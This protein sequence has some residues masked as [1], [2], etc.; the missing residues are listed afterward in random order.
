MYRWLFIAVAGLW[1]A[2]MAALI[3][4]DVWPA[5]TAQDAPRMDASQLGKPGVVRREQF[6]IFDAD[7]KPIG[8][9]WGEVQVEENSTT[10]VT[11]MILIDGMKLLPPLRVESR[12]EFDDK[13]ELSDFDL[14][15]Y[16]VPMTI[17]SVH[18]ERR[19]IYFPCEMHFG[20]MHRQ[21]N[22]EMSAS[23]MIG[24][25]LRPFA[26]LPKLH[27]GQSWR[28]QVLDPLSAV[29]GGK[30]EFRSV[31]AEVTGKEFITTEVSG[32]VE[33]FVVEIRGQQAK[34][35]VGPEGRVL[36]QEVAVPG[37]KRLA[38][39]EVRYDD[40]ARKEAV[41]RVRMM[42][43]SEKGQHERSN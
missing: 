40:E 6:S 15:V 25:S 43:K 30:S 28:M 24:E 23:R 19:G 10:T 26:V 2:A 38:L 7:N 27:L 32:R 29:Q 8:T 22:L 42:P 34:A 41:H 31:V 9:A 36:R 13:G 37:L 1:L 17:I 12:T 11:S 5:W 33:C 21:A 14:S 16:G 35:W 39:Q 3:R 20:P 4:R 18:G